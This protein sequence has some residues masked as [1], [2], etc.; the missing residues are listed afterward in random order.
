MFPAHSTSLH[1]MAARNKNRNLLSG[2]HRSD[3][4][5]NIDQTSQ[6]QSEP[7]IAVHVTGFTAQKAAR[8]KIIKTLLIACHGSNWWWDFNQTFTVSFNPHYA[9]HWHAALCCQ[10]QASELKLEKLVWLSQVKKL[11]IYILT[12]IQKISQKCFCDKHP[13]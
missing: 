4:W 11:P 8:A 10:K 1:K 12:L 13:F 7:T 3:S 2:F 9:Y 5:H 6:E